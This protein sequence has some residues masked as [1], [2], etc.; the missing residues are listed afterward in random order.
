MYEAQ[1][2]VLRK[3]VTSLV[4]PEATVMVTFSYVI[5]APLASYTAQI[6]SKVWG[7]SEK[8][9]KSAEIFRLN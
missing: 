3:N 5:S 2:L 6:G 7:L 8:F 1:L 9:R 4:L